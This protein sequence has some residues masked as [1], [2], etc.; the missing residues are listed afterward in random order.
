MI[1]LFTS[2]SVGLVLPR[3]FL[4]D[5]SS[6]L[7][8]EELIK[9]PSELVLFSFSPL[10]FGFSSFFP[11]VDWT[12]LADFVERRIQKTGCIRSLGSGLPR[13]S[14]CALLPPVSISL[15]IGSAGYKWGLNPWEC[16]FFCNWGT[17]HCMGLW[18]T[19]SVPFRQIFSPR[20]TFVRIYFLAISDLELSWRTHNGMVIKNSD[21]KIAVQ[22][23]ILIIWIL[24]WGL[25]VGSR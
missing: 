16:V 17:V 10:V 11:F 13:N 24:Q 22:H 15:T 9:P 18:C 14:F 20:S 5:T 4:E 25:S 6:H 2:A 1:L 12:G 7:F 23:W 19:F 3:M 21:F 8:W